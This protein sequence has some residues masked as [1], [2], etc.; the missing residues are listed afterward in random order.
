[1][2]CIGLTLPLCCRRVSHMLRL[3]PSSLVMTGYTEQF[4]GP[5]CWEVVQRY[6]VIFAVP[7]IMEIYHCWKLYIHK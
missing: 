4:S 6:L 7:L 5:V 3:N 2:E 1:M